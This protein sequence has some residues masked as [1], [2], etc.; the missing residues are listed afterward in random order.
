MAP[1]LCSRASY[2]VAVTSFGLNGVCA[3]GLRSAG[4]PASGL[5]LN[6]VVSPGSFATIVLCRRAV[7][8]RRFGES[9]ERA[10]MITARA[11]V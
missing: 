10:D 9:K 2:I 7:G 5:A 8:G 6:A 4:R 3:G 11:R 1:V